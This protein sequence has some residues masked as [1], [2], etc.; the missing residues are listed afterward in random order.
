M[1]VIPKGVTN[2]FANAVAYFLFGLCCSSRLPT[3]L[4]Y[5]CALGEFANSRSPSSPAVRPGVS[6]D[7]LSIPH[8]ESVASEASW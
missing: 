4:S 1:R 7:D 3:W 6:A 8:L 2:A 5:S